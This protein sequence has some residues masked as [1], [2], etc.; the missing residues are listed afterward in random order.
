MVEESP[1]IDYYNNNSTWY[2][3]G[4]WV[5]IFAVM[6]CYVCPKSIIIIVLYGLEVVMPVL[7]YMRRINVG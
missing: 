7:L 2:C 1:V 5:I 6:F 4:G 3:Y